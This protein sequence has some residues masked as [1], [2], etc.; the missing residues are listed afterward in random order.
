MILIF[1][2][3]NAALKA[4]YQVLSFYPDNEGMFHVRRQ[5]DDSHF[6]LALARSL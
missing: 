2:N 1:D 6:A 5:V 3:V 4:G